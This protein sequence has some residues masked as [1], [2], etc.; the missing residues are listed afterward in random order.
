[1]LNEDSKLKL[2]LPWIFACLT[3]RLLAEKYE[4][5]VVNCVDGSIVA[6]VPSRKTYCYHPYLL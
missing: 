1:V 5:D 6:S 3:R 2:W 4:S